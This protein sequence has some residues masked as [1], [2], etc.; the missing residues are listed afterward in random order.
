MWW[1]NWFG[2]DLRNGR[3]LLYHCWLPYFHL[4][5][6]NLVDWQ[7]C[8]KKKKKKVMIVTALPSMIESS[9]IHRCSFLL[10]ARFCFQFVFKRQLLKYGFCKKLL[11]YKWTSF[12][13]CFGQ[14]AVRALCAQQTGQ[15]VMEKVFNL[16][17]L[18]LYWDNFLQNPYFSQFVESK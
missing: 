11:W 1:P 18:H 13:S 5:V 10:S 7:Q 16:S 4:F 8:E 14:F 6:R 12:S 15:K 2:W 9:P 3:I 17:E